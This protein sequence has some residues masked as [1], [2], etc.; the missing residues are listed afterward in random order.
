MKHIR[1]WA[2]VGAFSLLAA[3]A[4]LALLHA[5]EA[6]DPGF[7][8]GS[9]LTTIKDA[10][11]NFASRSVITMHADQT[12]LAVD[13]A[14]E[15]PKDYFGSQ[16]GTWKPAGNHRIAART[17]NFRY[18]H[19]T[20]PGGVARSDY[21]ISFAPDRRQVTGTITLRTFPLEDGNPLEDEGTLIGT[22]TFEGEWIKP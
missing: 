4:S 8:D 2:A 18:P 19:G 21:V 9:Y 1:L 10:G 16:L 7:S 20:D 14:E 22:F 17:I 11:G 15:G 6:G 3:V 5:Q 13:S 12:I